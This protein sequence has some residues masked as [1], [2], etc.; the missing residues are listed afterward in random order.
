[1]RIMH[2]STRL[3][4]GG[5][6][7]NTVLSC[8]GQAR[9]G[10]DVSLVF[11]PIY[12]PEGSLLERVKNFRTQ[13]GRAIETIETPNLIRQIA[14]LRD[15]RCYGDLRR[16]IRTW[17]PD[18]VHT[19]SSKAGILGRAA[20]W[21]ERVHCVVHTIHGPP[22]HPY[23]KQWRNQLY[24]RSERFAAARCHKI[25][26]VADAMRDQFLAHDIG[27]PEQ[28]ITVRSGMEVER[29]LSPQW[30]REDVRRELGFA[31][32]DFVVGTVARLAE[33]KGHDD[34]IDALGPYMQQHPNLKLLWLGD[35]WLKERLMIRLKILG[36]TERVITTGLVPPEQI[37]SYMQ[38]M[39]VLIHPSYR[40]GLPRTVTQAL[41]SGIPA[42]AY[43]VDGTR[44]VCI[45]GETGRLLKAG[46]RNGLREATLW[47]MDHSDER[48]AMGRRG[49]ERCRNE[50]AAETM[51]ERLEA[52][53]QSCLK[54]RMNTNEHE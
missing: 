24:I 49:R 11:G 54:P 44:E 27:R 17:K 46:D 48:A 7:E 30:S 32:N 31:A 13:D 16:L 6:Q 38:A 18:V 53:Y 26:C 52:V 43:D 35:G 42:I 34:L 47:M 51:V 41:L 21:K 37:P 19:H 9:R 50:F 22:F 14:P 8:E 1:M 4:L 5:S 10:H 33:H 36:L 12:G 45:N 28:Y 20:A 3:I 15:W 23:E 39:Y 25:V 40:E 29:Y 2:I